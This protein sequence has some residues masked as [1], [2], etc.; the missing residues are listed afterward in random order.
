MIC[1]L[2]GGMTQPGFDDVGIDARLEQVDRGR[3]AHAVG[4]KALLGDARADARG[5]PEVALHDGA[6]AEA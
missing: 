2:D 3:V 1:A 5:E 4:R 6:D